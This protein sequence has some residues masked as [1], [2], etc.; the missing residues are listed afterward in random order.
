MSPPVKRGGV[1]VNAKVDFVLK[2][3]FSIKLVGGSGEI[4]IIAPFP[5]KDD[6]ELP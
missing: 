4:V 6:S 3:V 1:H 2:I 5:S